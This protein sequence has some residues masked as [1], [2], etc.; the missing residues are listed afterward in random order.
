[1]KSKKIKI[2][3]F[4]IN[5][6]PLFNKNCP[7]NFGGAEVQLYQLAKKISEDEKFEVC[8][9]VADE[10]Q[11]LVEN[12]GK[13]KVVKA[14]PLHNNRKNFLGKI[15]YG[16]L[17]KI[18]FLIKLSLINPSVCIQRA[19]GIETGILAFY[20]K[21]FKKNFVY[22]TANEYDCN[23]DYEK[24]NGIAGRSYAYGIKNAGLVITQNEDHKKMF[25]DSY[26]LSSIVIKSSY[27]IPE[28]QN[29]DKKYLLWVA[30]L[31]DLKQ[32]EIYINLAKKFPKENFV[33]I[34][35]KSD[36]V[37]YAE[38]IEKEASEIGNIEFIQKVPFEDIGRYFKEA[39]IFVNTSK[40][41]GFPNTFV[42]AAICGTPIVSLSVNPDNFIN[43]YGCGYCSER[44]EEKMVEQVKK[45]LEDKNDWQ[46]KS[47]NAFEYA[48]KD[49]DIENNIRKIKDILINFAKNSHQS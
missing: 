31:I 43:D 4:S 8:F 22:M 7:A 41:E 42:Q 14:Y 15:Y 48:R 38:E 35:P 47:K 49:H 40:I 25:K 46:E 3:F 44:N 17:K 11:K 16:V 33:M 24:K 6:Y 1:M 36:D 5:A 32:P 37:R 13:I 29:Y 27:S 28:H 9:F 2:C 39:K 34:G 45:L 23:G 30:R 12:Y 21:Y 18:I 19:A 10:G 20:C 26:G